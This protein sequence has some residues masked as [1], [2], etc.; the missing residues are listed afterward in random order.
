MKDKITEEVFRF[1]RKGLRTLV[2]AMREMSV[3]EFL[4]IDMSTQEIDPSVIAGEFEK[5]FTI[6]GCTGVEDELQDE[7]AECIEDFKD[8]GIKVWMLT[9]DLGHTAEEIGY[10]CG[11]ISRDSYTAEIFRLDSIDREELSA[12]VNQLGERIK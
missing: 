5:E 10:N 3:E 8:A 9:G 6:L 2:F 12:E 11:V 1:G 4:A 7:V